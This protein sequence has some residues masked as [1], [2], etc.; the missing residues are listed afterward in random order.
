LAIIVTT[1]SAFENSVTPSGLNSETNIVNLPLTGGI[2]PYIVEGYVDLT[3]MAAGDTTVITE[4][5]VLS[6]GGTAKQ[7]NQSTYSGV[8]T[9]PEI[10]ATS[11]IAKFGY[12]LTVNQTAG[13]TVRAYPYTLYQYIISQ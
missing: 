11:K 9:S 5:V 13:G 3:N 7:L 10:H 1:S 6:N 2:T 8:Q 4:Y 12:K